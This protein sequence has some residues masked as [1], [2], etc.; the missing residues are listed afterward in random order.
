[1]DHGKINREDLRPLT[2]KINKSENIFGDRIFLFFK[3]A[4]SMYKSKSGYPT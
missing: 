1:M 4:N 2:K 3:R